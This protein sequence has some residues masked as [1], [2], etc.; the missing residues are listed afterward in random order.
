MQTHFVR[1]NV[2]IL[3]KEYWK[4]W[5]ERAKRSRKKFLNSWCDIQQVDNKNFIEAFKKTPV[6]HLFKKDYISYYSQMYDIEPSSIRSYL[7]YHNWLAIA[8]L[9]VHDFHKSSVHLVAF[10]HRKYYKLQAGTWLI[11]KWF[12]DSFEKR[13]EYIDFDRLK[14][15]YWPKDQQWYSDFK[16]NFIEFETSFQSAYFKIF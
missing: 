4:K 11:D 5:N 7:V 13:I 14:E 8:G 16:K 3:Q 6:R 1:A 2:T 9:A 10:T 15:P 12:Q